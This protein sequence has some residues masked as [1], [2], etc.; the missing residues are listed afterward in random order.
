MIHFQYPARCASNLNVLGWKFHGKSDCGISVLVL[1]RELDSG[2][3]VRNKLREISILYA[4]GCLGGLASLVTLSGF[5]A[6]GVAS[7]LGVFVPYPW[8]VS[9]FYPRIVWGGLWALLFLLR[10]FPGS[11]FQ[12]ALLLSLIPS[13][14]ELF[15]VFPFKGSGLL[16]WQLGMWT[17][18][19]VL[20]ANAVWG[21]TTAVH[22]Y[23][24][25]M[26]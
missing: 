26:R 13:A 20:V 17:P 21:F 6:Y 11:I 2:R 14:F 10:L 18:L 1:S 16:G 5:R 15:V 3:L 25:R 22:L 23:L 8:A 7:V 4:A 9:V 12:R 24:V 19:F